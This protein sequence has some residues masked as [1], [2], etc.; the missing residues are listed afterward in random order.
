MFTYYI[1]PPEFVKADSL[2][3]ER[4]A[5]MEQLKSSKE[6]VAYKMG[7]TYNATGA[8]RTNQVVYSCEDCEK[9]LEDETIICECCAIFCHAGHKIKKGNLGRPIQS[10]CGMKTY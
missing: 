8:R 3:A 5:V 7:C 10:S 1:D 9:D 2:P 6:K 4:K